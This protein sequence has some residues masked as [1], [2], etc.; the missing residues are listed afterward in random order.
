MSVKP[1]TRD[2]SGTLRVAATVTGGGQYA[3][4]DRTPADIAPLNSDWPLTPTQEQLDRAAEE[5]ARRLAIYPSVAEDPRTLTARLAYR[6]AIQE[7]CYQ[8]F[9]QGIPHRDDADFEALW[10]SDGPGLTRAAVT[11]RLDELHGFLATATDDTAEELR[12]AREQAAH[13]EEALRCSGRNLS[14]NQI[15]V[16]HSRVAKEENTVPF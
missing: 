11:A 13:L 3:A 1:T 12:D 16:T 5:T 7:D 10:E 9:L 14:I 2:Q 6:I 15:I 4:H 8:H